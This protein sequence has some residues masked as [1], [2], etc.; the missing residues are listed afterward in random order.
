MFASMFQDLNVRQMQQNRPFF[1]VQWLS[2]GLVVKGSF[3]KKNSVIQ[4]LLFSY[5]QYCYQYHYIF[6]VSVVSA[7]VALWV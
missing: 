5:Y 1:K 2:F 3:V 6:G 7:C 4:I